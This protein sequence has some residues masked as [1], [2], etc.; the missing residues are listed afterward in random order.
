MKKKLD[1]KKLAMLG[2]AGGSMLA[3]QAE[4]TLFDNSSTS[5]LLAYGCGGSN[6]CHGSSAPSTAQPQSTPAQAE[7]KA[8]QSTTTPAAQGQVAYG[9]GAASS[10][11]GY[12]YNNNKQ[13][14]SSCAAGQVAYGCGAPSSGQG[15]N[16]NNQPQP[17]PAQPQQSGYG[18]NQRQPQSSCGA[19]P[20]RNEQA[21]N[22]RPANAGASFSN[23]AE[24]TAETPWIQGDMNTNGK[25]APVQN[26]QVPAKPEAASNGYNQLKK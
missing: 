16:Y 15:Y 26:G 24:N 23:T 9:C 6:G 3:S 25:A 20:A 5:N 11:Q 18:Y 8:P 17:T 22:A 10:G 14:Q 21:Y 4:A 13:P 2:I 19:A 1:F 7:P 12:N